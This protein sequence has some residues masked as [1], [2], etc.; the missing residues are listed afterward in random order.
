MKIYHM[1]YAIQITI[2]KILRLLQYLCCKSVISFE[3][4]NTDKIPINLLLPNKKI[5]RFMALWVILSK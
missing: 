5:A 4:T 2:H 1:H 3:T